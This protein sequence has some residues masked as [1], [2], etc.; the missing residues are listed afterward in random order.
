MHVNV[1]MGMNVC[2]GFVVC[3]FVHA[4]WFLHKRELVNISM[5]LLKLCTQMPERLHPS[6]PGD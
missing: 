5:Y 6:F 1:R 4:M 3:L 2:L